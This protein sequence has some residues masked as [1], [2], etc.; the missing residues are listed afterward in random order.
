M[1]IPLSPTSLYNLANNN[2][3]EQKSGEVRI[4]TYKLVATP[5]LL[6]LLNSHVPPTEQQTPNRL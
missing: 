1:Y 5:S 4:T 6:L 3:K 2:L